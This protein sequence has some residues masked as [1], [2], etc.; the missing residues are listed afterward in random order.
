MKTAISTEIDYPESD[1]EPMAETPIHVE[2]IILL[3]QAFQDYFRDRPDVF[4]A[5][6]I[7]WYWQ[8]G[9]RDVCISPDVMVVPGVVPREVGERRSFR[10]WEEGGAVPAV[11]FEMASRGTWR[12][13]R[14]KKLRKYESLGVSEYFI[15]DPDAKYV[16]PPLIGFRLRNGVYTPID[17][18]EPDTLAS[19]LG[20]HLRPEGLMLRLI[21]GKTGQPIPTRLERAIT[22]EAE[23]ERLRALLQQRE[24]T[25]GSGA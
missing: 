15:F 5:S 3:H 22:L 19:E 21:D 12:D 8:E 14:V 18:V 16:V 7:F 1:D 10:S 20:F 24:G 13:D 6:D 23:V 9:N 25:N 17:E 4:V 2:A 11:V